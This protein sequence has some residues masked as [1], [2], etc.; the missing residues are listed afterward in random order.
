MNFSNYYIVTEP[1]ARNLKMLGCDLPCYFCYDGGG[2]RISLSEELSKGLNYNSII[3]KGCCSA[4]YRVTVM[5]WI[6]NLYSMNLET[7]LD[8]EKEGEW[9]YRI[10]F[11]DEIKDKLKR[12]ANSKMIIYE[13]KRL[14]EL[15]GIEHMIEII[16]NYFWE[17]KFNKNEVL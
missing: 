11:N 12:E 8:E 10:E 1:I 9:R 3:F 2:N 7:F 4:P 17:I 15:A 6:K 14:A 16:F 5:D 13:S